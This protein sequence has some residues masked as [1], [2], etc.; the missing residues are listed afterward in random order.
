MSSRR[1]T[2][3]TIAASLTRIY[4]QREAEAAARILI[5]EREG[6]S[7]SHLLAYADEECAI[8]QRQI[9]TDTARLAAGVPLQYLLGH[10]EFCGLDFEVGEGV[11]IPRPETEELVAAV[12]QKTTPD[13]AILDLCTGSGCIAVALAKRMKGGTVTAADISE[14]ALGYARRNALRNAVEV[15]FAEW[16][17]FREPPFGNGRTFDAIVSNPPY[18]PASEKSSMSVNVTTYEP[19]EAL[20]VPDAEPLLFYRRIAKL[21]HTLLRDGGS[22]CFEVHERLAGDTAAMLAAEGYRDAEIIEDVNLKPR[23]VCCRK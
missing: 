18:I 8:P 1:E 23:I 13:A 7:L 3:R 20:F 6:V 22:L 5:S 15:E 2:I 11:L 14:K 10:C 21:G 19:H 16:D 17:I 9:E 12:L 4:T